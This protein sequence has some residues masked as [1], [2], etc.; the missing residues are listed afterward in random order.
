[1]LKQFLIGDILKKVETKKV[2]LKKSDC[3]SVYTNEYNLPARTA[4]TQNQGLSCF[5]PKD[6]ATV[7]INKISVSA[8]GDFCAFWHDTNF[9]IL[10]D[11]YAL[12]GNGFEL[13]EKKAL[14]I[15]ASMYKTLEKKY[16]WNNKSGWEKIKKEK[17][18]LPIKIDEKNNPIID[19]TCFYHEEG[20]IPDFEYMEKYISELEKEHIIELEKYLSEL[21]KYL[22]ATVLNSYE[23]V[24]EDKKILSLSQ[25]SIITEE[26]N[27]KNNSK[28]GLQIREFKC[29]NLF[30]SQTGDVDL[31]QKDINGKGC[32]F[33]NSGIENNGIKGKTDRKAKI[34]PSNTITIDFWGN[35]YYR[36][37]EYKM[38]THNHVFSLSGDVIKNKHVGLYIVS[39]MNYMK[40]IFSYS[41]MGTWNKIKELDIYLPIQTNDKNEPIIDK[42]YKYHPNGYVP[43]FEYMEKYIK[44]IEK[45]VIKDVVLFKDKIL[46]ETKNIVLKEDKDN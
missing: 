1:M 25:D 18:Y 14:Y 43:D 35:A 42:E 46:Q 45:L 27:Y 26:S 34:F 22:M 39:R 20:F 28:N 16:N 10:Q 2:S 11:S 30:I 40:K 15:I 32:Y 7:L 13:N 9:T 4:T 38:A 23:L 6:M 19:N 12:D 17:L 3:S 36:D 33:I 21:E 5:V 31:Q 44:A 24:E 41:N 29:K 8:N 37:F